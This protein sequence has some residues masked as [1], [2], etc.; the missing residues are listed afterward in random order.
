M[1]WGGDQPRGED[2][3]RVCGRGQ[4]RGGSITLS[5]DGDRMTEEGGPRPLR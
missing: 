3:L 5:R 1:C 2:Q 4:P